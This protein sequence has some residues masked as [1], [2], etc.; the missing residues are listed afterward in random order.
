M[1][2]LSGQISRYAP[3]N[4][5][6]ALGAVG[7]ALGVDAAVTLMVL[8]HSYAV[9]VLGAASR[10]MPFA[11]TDAQA[12]LRRLHPLLERLSGEIWQRHWSEMWAFSP[13]LDLAAMNHEGDEVRL[14]AS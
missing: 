13:E 1:K 3:G 5:A 10:L 6:V 12:I 7:Q 11:H 4:G 8:C 2:P 14:F 9:S